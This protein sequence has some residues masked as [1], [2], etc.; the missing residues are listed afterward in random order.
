MLF[1]LIQGTGIDSSYLARL[2]DKIHSGPG[3]N[4]ETLA[5]KNTLWGMSGREPLGNFAFL[6]I[7]KYNLEVKELGHA[8]GY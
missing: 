8:W 1:A 3:S 4:L 5:V 7:D 2:K 6:L